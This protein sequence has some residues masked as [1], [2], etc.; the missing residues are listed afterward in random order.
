MKCSQIIAMLSRVMLA[1]L[2]LFA[3][4]TRGQSDAAPACTAAEAVASLGTGGLPDLPPFEVTPVATPAATTLPV[5]GSSRESFLYPAPPEESASGGRVIAADARSG[6]VLWDSQQSAAALPAALEHAP[7]LLEDGEGRAYRAYFGDAAGN[8]W[9][10]DL[11]RGSEAEWRLSRLADLAGLAGG[12]GTVS[13]PVA[14]DLFLGIDGSGRPF[15]GLVLPALVET[16]AGRRIDLLLLR[17]YALDQG[18]APEPV[19]ADDL[20]AARDCES[21]GCP[22]D[23]GPGWHLADAAPG[24]ALA[25]APLIDGGRIFLATHTQLSLDCDDASAERFVVIVDLESAL[26]LFGGDDGDAFAVG[27][28]RLDGPRPDG[29]VVHLPGLAEALAAEGVAENVL[30]ARGLAAR[31]CYWLDLLLDSD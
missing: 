16:A 28:R 24:D 15:D 26:P 22:P 27:R 1:L 17:D 14:P 3:A 23:T 8:V 2:Q 25:V 11:P 29:A 13:F 4:E 20:V 19:R 10:L 9:R 12:S 6:A 18:D 7:A 21:P 5:D 31:R 30:E